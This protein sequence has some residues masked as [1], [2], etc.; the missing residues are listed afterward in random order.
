MGSGKDVTATVL[1]GAGST[2]G[3]VITFTMLKAL[4][5]GCVY[6]I[7]VLFTASGNKYEPY[8]IVH[9]EY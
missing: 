9:A 8:L 1:S 2:I 7:E 6:R 5:V 4:T 3:Q